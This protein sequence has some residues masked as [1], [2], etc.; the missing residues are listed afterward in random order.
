[1]ACY[2]INGLVPVVDPT[3]FVHP[4]AILVGD[5]IIGASCYVAPGAS[6]RGDFGRIIL[7]RGSNVQDNCVMH[8]FPG[9]DTVIEEDGHI[10]HG[11]ILHG[12]I[13]K[14]NAMVGM[15]SVVMDEAVVGESAIVAA[16]AFVKAGMAIPPR[17]LAVGAPAKVIR[18]LS[19]D[20]LKWKMNGTRSYH[21]LTVR[22]LATLREVQPLNAVE[23]D[24][25]RIT[26]DVE[27]VVP[28]VAARRD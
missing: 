19:D 6:L 13:V 1:V 21:E 16:G 14:K 28:L 24:R 4:M 2:E 25:K 11:A 18:P 22:S 12:C 17:S 26:S 8:G 3:A 15:N 7:E 5:V 27:G 10:G 23:P 20:E 9:T